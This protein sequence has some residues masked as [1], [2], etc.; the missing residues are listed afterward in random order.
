MNLSPL[1]GALAPEV[2]EKVHVY[3]A[4]VPQ[5]IK[6]SLILQRTMQG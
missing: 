2:I 4:D 3:A 6:P 1:C 5:R